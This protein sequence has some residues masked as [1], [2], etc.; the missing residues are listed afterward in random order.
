MNYF[1]EVSPL[2][3]DNLQHVKFS[4]CISSKMIRYSS[5]TLLPALTKLG[6]NSYLYY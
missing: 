5:Y 4:S 1:L 6:H 3:L 2:S